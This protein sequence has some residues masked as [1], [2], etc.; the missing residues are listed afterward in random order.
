MA[1]RI[2]GQAVI[3]G[4][5]MKNMDRYAVSVRKPNGKIETKVEECVSFAEK[6]PLFQLPVFRGMANFL[7]SMVIGMKTLN[8]SASFYEDEEE[9]TESRTKQLLEKI[10]GE[11]AEKIIMGIVLVFSL[12]ISIGLFMIL[13]YIASEALGKLIR[14]EYVILFMEGII[15]IAIFLGYIVL[16]SRMEDIKRVFMYHGAEHKTINCLEAGVPLTPENVDN[17]SRLHKR[18]GTSFIFIVMIIS[19]VFFFFIRVDTIWLRIVL[20]LLFLPLVAGV[21]YE[22]IRLAGSS[23]HPLVQIFSKPGLALQKLT[24]KEPDH[25][26]IEVAIASVEGVFDWREYLDSL[27]KGEQKEDE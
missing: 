24:T 1:V 15:R 9:Q 7:E 13:P 22:F 23:D 4:V 16:I 8:Y 27:N 14:N 10:L 21:S 3:E 6:H 17:F 26:M 18:C 5:M 2:G 19:M 12:A 11:K 20:R 25:S